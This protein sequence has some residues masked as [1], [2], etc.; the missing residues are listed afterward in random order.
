MKINVKPLLGILFL[1]SIF[2]ACSDDDDSSNNDNNAALVAEITNNVQ[3]GNWLI[4]SFIDSNQDETNDFNGYT[5]TFA[6]NGELIA[7]NNSTTLTGT[8]SVTDD[9]DSN[10]DSS[11]DDDDIDFNIF[12]PVD[13]DND[14]EDLNDDWDIVNQSSTKIELIDVS[15][16]NGGTDYLTFEKI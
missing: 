11:S 4:T 15:G 3:D 6:D 10:D 1:A 13:D 9:D 16:G 7:T 8:W 2:V 5:F 12:F 14:F